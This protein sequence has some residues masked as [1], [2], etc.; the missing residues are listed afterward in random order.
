MHIQK[1]KNIVKKNG[2]FSEVLKKSTSSFFLRIFGFGLNY[3][4][5]FI[6][7]Y[8]FSNSTWG[9][10][11][12]C[13][14]IIQILGLIGGLGI[15]IALI[16]IVALKK[17]DLLQLYKTVIIRVIFFNVILSGLIYY[18]SNYIGDL[19]GKDGI[20]MTQYI[21][22]AS[23]GILPFSLTLI[24]GGLFRGEKKIISFSFY[25]SL[26]RFLFANISLI[27]LLII[28][29]NDSSIVIFSF[30]IGLYLLCLFSMKEAFK[31]LKLNNLS[32]SKEKTNELLS[33]NDVI[34]LSIP[35]F[36]SN[37]MNVG[38]FYSITLILGFILTKEEVGF[39][40]IVNRLASILT[41]VLYAVNSISASKFAES[42]TNLKL[43]QTNVQ[44]ASK[45]IFYSTTL[46]FTF[47]L[48]TGSYI[49]NLIGVGWVQNS[50]LLFVII[51]LGQLVNNLSGSVGVLLQMT[52]FHKQ[53]RNIAFGSFVFVSV[54]L[55]FITPIYGLI[56]A[57]IVVG[58]N[59]ALKNIIAMGY[60]L[61]KK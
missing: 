26:G 36:W 19:F 22:I 17:Y 31:I 2:D 3:L 55:I 58:L 29:G 47:M 6:V 11:A 41:I 18:F 59:L 51:L 42:S 27:V 12:I 9:I 35:L 5:L 45:I 56:G 52:G 37:F 14:S 13:L 8:F 50:Y 39:F 46:I 57:A 49:L 4:F 20:N 43:L 44:N 48:L 60:I 28:Y 61:K 25:D 24:N 21:K 33:F 54:S 30:V 15:N 23:F 40:D 1:I 53:A 38:T 7:S 16:K 32:S 10:F 34:K